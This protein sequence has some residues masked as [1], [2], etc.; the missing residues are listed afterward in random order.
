MK[1]ILLLLL[2]VLASL[3]ALCQTVDSNYTPIVREGSEWVF[4]AK[5]KTPYKYVVG[6]DT[7]FN[8]V[9][10][11]KLYRKGIWFI[12]EE[13]GDVMEAYDTAVYS[14]IREENK[15]VYQ[16]RVNSNCYNAPVGEIAGKQYDFESLIYD[17]NDIEAFYSNWYREFYGDAA[18]VG[19]QFTKEGADTNL[20]VNR[21]CY[22]VEVGVNHLLVE[23][24]GAY[25]PVSGYGDTF[26]R[27]FCCKGGLMRYQFVSMKNGNGE[28]EYFDS[29][30]YSKMLREQHDT[31]NDNMVD[32]TDL[33]IVC[34]DV[35]GI[36]QEKQGCYLYGSITE[37]NDF[38]VEDI[39]SV[40]NYLLGK[41]KSPV[42]K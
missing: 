26:H 42:E 35:L 15:K 8:G 19:K 23:A 27:V 14:L 37:D 10:Y 13:N 9:L 38:D 7:I 4:H 31:N 20:L 36:G 2:A 30:L 5:D 32:V 12:E 3:S 33:N 24:I 6:N 16:V 39:N 25:Y 41:T 40:I 22:S 18:I 34:N 17:F 28:Y 11:K 21:H 1:Q 29:D